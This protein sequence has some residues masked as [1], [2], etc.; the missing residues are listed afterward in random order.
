MTCSREPRIVQSPPKKLI[1][2]HQKMS[3][4]TDSTGALWLNFM[5][6]RKRITKAVNSDLFAMQ[7]YDADYFQHFDPTRVF[8]K[9]AA[10]EVSEFDPVPEQMEKFT[11]QGGLY[12]VFDHR[13]GPATGAETFTY[14]FRNWLPNSIY[15]LDDRP[16][17]E[18]LGEKYKN[19]EPD[20]EEEIWIPIRKNRT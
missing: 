5:P 19:N 20:S 14:I 18:I 16:H 15:E 8:E 10:I 3:L 17:F 7:L 13:G 4:A 6:Q 12:A 9:W 2:I 1:G 11:L